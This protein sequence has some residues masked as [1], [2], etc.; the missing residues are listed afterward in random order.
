[1]ANTISITLTSIECEG[2]SEGTDEV[3][4]IYQADCGRPT[5]V[6]PAWHDHQSMDAGGPPWNINLEMSFENDVLVT[7]YDS[8]VAFNPFWSEYLVSFD[9][10]P[11]NIPAS[12]T[13]SNPNGARYTLNVR[14]SS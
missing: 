13:L 1:M 10:T 14:R 7:L 6:P 5:R 9:Y 3:Y 8:D 11:I 12:V 2:T 4:V